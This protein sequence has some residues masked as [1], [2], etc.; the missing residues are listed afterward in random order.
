MAHNVNIPKIN[1][2]SQTAAIEMEGST[3]KNQ[4]LL[5]LMVAV[6]YHY[7]TLEDLGEC[8]CQR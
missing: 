1:D 8:V 3:G 6:A 2:M 4:T 7:I 5:R